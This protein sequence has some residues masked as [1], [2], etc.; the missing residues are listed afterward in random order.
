MDIVQHLSTAA[1]LYSG[2]YAQGCAKVRISA[3]LPLFFWCG[4]V[5]GT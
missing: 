5:L 3:S 4:Q 2:V 1:S